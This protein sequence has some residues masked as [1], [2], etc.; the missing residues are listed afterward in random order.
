MQNFRETEEA[1]NNAAGLLAAFKRFLRLGSDILEFLL[2]R[3][4]QAKQICEKY[5][6]IIPKVN[7]IA[8]KSILLIWSRIE[9]LEAYE[10]CNN[11]Q[12]SIEEL[13]KSVSYCHA[14]N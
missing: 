13:S 3:F 7:G 12:D 4:N 1:I 10:F 11:L 5:R 8:D 9:K 6:S 14:A 2:Q